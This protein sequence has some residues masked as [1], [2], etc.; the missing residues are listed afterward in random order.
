MPHRIRVVPKKNAKRAISSVEDVRTWSEH[1]RGKARILIAAA[2]VILVMACGAG[3]YL[4]VLSSNRSR[5]QGALTEAVALYKSASGSDERS[6]DQLRR[7]VAEFMEIEKDFP[8]TFQAMMASYYMGNAKFAL[9]D[10]AGAAEVYRSFLTRYPDDKSMKY[11]VV[12]RLA[13][14]L[15]RLG[16]SDEAVKMFGQL[17]GIPDAP[18][19]DQAYFEQGRL[20]EA[21]NQNVAA[22]SMYEEISKTFPQSPLAPAAMDR[23][24]VLGGGEKK[25]RPEEAKPSGK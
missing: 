9:G 19:R 21:K 24:R 13:L 2:A 10:M 8:K 7:A 3:I 15:E 16:N 1:I 20:F 18:N 23:I 14:T 11:F 5:A 22:L 25:G 12:N 6:A 4:I 17:T